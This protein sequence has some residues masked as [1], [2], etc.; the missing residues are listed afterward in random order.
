MSL[1][2]NICH[3]MEK[4][5]KT[6]NMEGAWKMMSILLPK[7]GCFFSIRFLFFDILYQMR[8]V[9]VFLSMSRSLGKCS[10]STHWTKHGKLVHILFPNYGWFFSIRFSI[11]VFLSYLMI[12]LEIHRSSH[13]YPIVLEKASKSIS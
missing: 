2:I 6:H 10:E 1:S 13:Q 7:Y 4:S 11:M 12:G 8:N 9:W 5:R 3:S